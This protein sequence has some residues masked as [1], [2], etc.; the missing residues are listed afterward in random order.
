MTAQDE[1]DIV[2]FLKTLSDGYEPAKL[3]SPN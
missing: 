1:A 2:E 3:V